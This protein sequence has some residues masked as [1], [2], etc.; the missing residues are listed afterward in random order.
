MKEIN[1]ANSSP[2]Y[3]SSILFVSPSISLYII[4]EVFY[5]YLR[6]Y[7]VLIVADCKDINY[8][9]E[10]VFWDTFHTSQSN[11]CRHLDE[12]MYEKTHIFN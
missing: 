9:N 10:I 1:S 11:L 7:V 4:R 5:I 8:N 3:G 2:T 12:M 6:T